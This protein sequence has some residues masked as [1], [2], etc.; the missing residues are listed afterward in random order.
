M[1]GLAELVQ[2]AQADVA[3]HALAVVDLEGAES[4]D[5]IA[6]LDTAGEGAPVELQSELFTAFR[7]RQNWRRRDM[8]RD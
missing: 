7:A 8:I 6:A 1:V 2:A 5:G 4:L 3:A